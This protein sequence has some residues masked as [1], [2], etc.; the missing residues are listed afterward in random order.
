[1]R[2][3]STF[4][5]CTILLSTFVLAQTASLPT[6]GQLLAPTVSPFLESP[7]ASPQF[8]PA[9]FVDYNVAYD[10]DGSINLAAGQ[11]S[12]AFQPE[13][14]TS[15]GRLPLAFEANQGQTDPHVKFFAHRGGYALYLTATD[16]IL[17]LHPSAKRA[18][19]HR[20]FLRMKLLGANAKVSVAGSDELPGKINYFIG[21]DASK[22]RE[23]IPTY[24]KVHYSWVY[25]GVDLVYY[26]HEGVLEYDFVVSPGGDPSAIHVQFEGAVPVV[27]G[28]GDLILRTSRGD[29]VRFEKPVVYQ[30][31][32]SEEAEQHGVDGRRYIDGRFLVTADHGVSFQI[33]SYDKRR[34]L[35]IDP[36]LTYSTYLGGSNSDGAY[37]L[38][39]DSAGNAYITGGATSTDFPTTMGTYQTTFGGLNDN[40]T[41]EPFFQC[42]DVFVTKLNPTGTQLLWS[43]YLGGISSEVGFA[44]FVDATGVYVG[45]QTS[46]T[47]FPTTSGA[48]QTALPTES[49]R[50]GFVTKLNLA[51]SQLLYSTYLSGSIKDKLHG[52]AVDSSE[53]A[54]V[55]GETQSSDFPTT[56]GAF[57]TALAGS[58]NAFVTKLNPSGTG[59]VYS[60][61]LGGK[62]GD[63]ASSIAIDSSG[64][65]YV[66][67]GA[68]SP[69]FPTQ[70]PIQAT[71]GGGGTT[72]PAQ[73]ATVCGDAFVTVLNP[74]GSALLFSTYLGGSGEDSGL[75]IALDS[76]GNIYVSGGTDSTNFPTTAGVFQPTFGGGSEGCTNA[77]IAC[78]DAFLTEINAA[79][80]AFVYST[81]LGGSGDDIGGLGLVLDAAGNVHMAGLTGS[82]DFPVSANAV[83]ATFGGGSESCS[84]GFVC[85]DA[86]VTKFSLDASTLAFS[87]YL[88]GSSDDG[89]GNIAQDGAGN[90][91]VVGVT[92]SSD[93]SVTAGVY[94]PSCNS[95]VEGSSNT[96]VAE[97]A[98]PFPAVTLSPM[99]VNFGNQPVGVPSSPIS[100]T[101]TNS[102]TDSLLITSIVDANGF[103][104][105]NNCPVA[106][107]PLTAT[108]SCTINVTF[109]PTSPG[110]ANDTLTITDDA[111]GSPQMVPLT[112]VGAEPVVS[113]SPTSLTFASQTIG[114]TSTS[115]QITLS[116]TGNA[117][118]A[119]DSITITGANAGEFNLTN[120]C[121]ASLAADSS[122]T[123][124][125]TFTPTAAGNAT[126][127]VTVTDNAAGSPQTVSLTGVGAAT[128]APVVS[129]TPATLN[130]NGQ[131]VGI[132][133]IQ[134]T[135]L[136]NTG[137]AVLDIDSIGITGANAEE[138]SQTNTCGKTLAANANCIITVTFTPTTVGSA[139][140][141]ISV[142]DNAAGSPQT[143]PLPAAGAPFS[144][145]TTCTSLTVVPGQTAIFSVD[146]AAAG[147]FT[148]TVAL[149][150]SG[151][152]T[153]ATCTP[154][155]TSMNLSGMTPVQ[156]QVTATTT[157]A[158]GF[159][160]PP[161]G[162]ANENRLAGLVGLGGIAGL[163][164]LV[165]LPGNRRGKSARSKNRQRLYGFIALICIL[166]TLAMLPSCA[167]VSDPPGTA[168][169]TYP[170]TVTGT[171]QQPTGPAI[172]ETVT[173]NLVVQ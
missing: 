11:F 13:L 61:F 169:G 66:T 138:F 139:T 71:F 5:V 43:T 39:V 123:I 44:I 145:T 96:F 164:G 92:S 171:F 150:C 72:C 89:A 128:G 70:N 109:T 143:V 126:G 110:A 34:S 90:D 69:D 52:L 85:G 87:T 136:T 45:G 144:L 68:T 95:C 115:Q 159:L 112:G 157:Q 4:G 132:S 3:A 93:F 21:N 137:T 108:E 118:L 26:G 38:F 12:H 81:Y 78:G 166:A 9:N 1:M 120:G 155:S 42:G 80:T 48:F 24:S 18:G 148:P 63:A 62:A 30:E 122:C 82:T 74:T 161:F 73:H 58:A 135:T 47:N 105:T 59:L 170:L 6:I 79:R 140:A 15:Y 152:P 20:A 130:F 55:T 101:L 67:G 121:S 160:H 19:P 64:D 154:A 28:R 142:N 86:F 50:G 53:S 37:G 141:S 16:A 173:F 167:G 49:T 113:L 100:V 165:I 149:S 158:T 2:S 162:G 97:L 14:R 40:C 77:G 146:L 31:M 29:E 41:E 60:T 23:N 114:T 91:Y 51:G 156:V 172:T 111:A 131:A 10:H 75:G 84:P 163:A 46:S 153:L 35:V 65:A 33:G 127:S 119:I 36:V 103:S 7:D 147:D 134:Q 99:S 133:V 107:T 117:V 94:Q 25:P 98:I 151:A 27:D 129:L 76:A 116:N 56:N 54:Y 57:Q 22:W 88:G 124:S 168:S 125:V 32:V 102:G 106:P 8:A 83:Q 104:Q 17:S